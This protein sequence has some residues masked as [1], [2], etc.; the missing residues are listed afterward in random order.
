[1]WIIFSVQILCINNGKTKLLSMAGQLWRALQRKDIWVW[2]IDCWTL[3]ICKFM[4]DLNV[5]I[6]KVHCISLSI[7][8]IWSLSL[9][10]KKKKKKKKPHIQKEICCKVTLL[11]LMRTAQKKIC[12]TFLLSA[13][14]FTE[15]LKKKFRHQNK[16]HEI[17]ENPSPCFLLRLFFFLWLYR[18]TKKR[19]FFHL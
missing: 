14:V 17:F 11:A 16:F 12:L 4:N 7:W 18:E 6:L 15:R 5:R 13:G 10:R 1:M 3:K 19:T 2:S 9:L 8:L